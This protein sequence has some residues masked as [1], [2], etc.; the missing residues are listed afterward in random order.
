M[1]GMARTVSVSGFGDWKQLQAEMERSGIVMESASDKI[2][3]AA[4]DAGKAAAVQAEMAGKSADEQEAAAARASTAVV[5]A[6]ARITKAQQAAAAAAA[7]VAARTGASADAQ[8]AAA[9][10]AAAAAT[11]SASQITRA[12]QAAAAAAAKT[13]EAAGLS[14]DGQVAAADRAMAAQAELEAK[15]A[16]S[17]DRVSG[18]FKKLGTSMGS[19][20]IPFSGSVAKIGSDVDEAD[21]KMGKLGA[22]MVALGKFTAIAG[23]GAFAAAAY[24]GVKGAS[25]L[26]K[27]MEMIH[28]QAGASQAEVKKMTGAVLELS[29]LGTGPQKLSE[30]L[31]H[32]ESVGLRG[33]KAL[34]VLKF[35]AQ[36][37]QVGNA[38]LVDVQNA[39]DAAVVSG[40]S[41]AQ[42]YSQAM[43]ALNATV[44]SGDMKMQDLADA[45]GTGLLANVKQAGLSLGD[46]G[47]AL[48]VFGDNNLRGAEAATKLSS[49]V[50]I[51]AAPSKAAGEALGSIGI[52][53]TQ[54]GTDMQRGGLVPAI[55]DLKQHLHDSG[56][57]AAQ[58]ELVLTRA[59]GGRQSTGVKIL[60]E[61]LER[62][63]EKQKDLSQGSG[64]FGA[65]WQART[66][67]LSFQIDELEATVQKL[68][69][70]LGTALIPK[71][72]EVGHDTASVISWMEKHKAAA[73][74]LGAVIA[75]VLGAAVGA[76]AETKAVA[77]VNATKTM[78][79]G[80]GTLAS[81]VQAGSGKIVGAFATQDAAAQVSATQ[82][83]ADAEASS[84]AVEAEA[85]RI[86]AADAAIGEAAEGAA[87]TTDAALG[88]TG[89]G[90]VLV[91]LG[92][93]AYELETHWK[94]VMQ[95]L[96]EA[97]QA[98][99]NAVISELNN[100]IKVVEDL[101]LGLV[102]IDKI[103]E[104]SG[105][106]EASTQEKGG[107][108]VEAA[109]GGAEQKV[110]NTGGGIM[111][112]FESKGLTPAQ[113]A[114]IVGNFQ[115]E[116]S[117]NPGMNT[118]EGRGLDS[119]TGGRAHGGTAKQ[120]LEAY[121]KEL[122]GPEAGTLAQL[123]QA[124]S[125]REAA[126]VFEK[127]FERA[128]QPEM[129]NRE[130]FAEKAFKAHPHAA[131]SIP[132]ASEPGGAGLS[133]KALEE[134]GIGGETAAEKAK[135][136]AAALGVPA[137]VVA[138]LSTAKAL[139]GTKYT[140]GGGHDG[141]DPIAALKKIGVDCSGF[142]SQTLHRGGVLTNPVTTEGLATAPG[143][144]KGAG[145][146]VTLYDKANAGG[147]SHV[148]EEILGKYFESGGNPKYNP[149]GGVSLLT[150][151]QAK[152]ELSSGGFEAFHPS[153]LNKPVRGGADAST[154]AK[155][156][157]PQEA[158]ATAEAARLKKAEEELKKL[159]GSGTALY[160]K[161]ESDIQGGGVKILEKLLG[162]HSVVK[163]SPVARPTLT[164]IGSQSGKELDKLVAEL[165]GTHE[166]A[167]VQIADKLVAA[168]KSALAWLNVELVAE[169]EKATAQGLQIQ[170]A[171]EK[172]RTTLMADMASKVVEAMK[173]AAA[174]MV[175][176][177]DNATTALKDAGKTI[178][179]TFAAAAT[180]IKDQTQET[181]DAN[182]AAIQQIQDRSQTE[183]DKLAE[184]GLY[185]LNLVAQQQTVQLDEMKTA[186]D[187]QIAQAQQALDT[188]QT[189][190]DQGAAAVQALVDAVQTQQDALIG[191]AKL[192]LGT[193]E[194]QQDAAV[195]NAQVNLDNVTSSTDAAVQAAQSAVEKASSSTQAE[196]Q[197]AAAQLALAQGQQ[198]AQVAQAEAAL[199]AAK[200]ASSSAVEN[201]E[202]AL[203]AAE[204]HGGLAETE[205]ENALASAQGNA[206]VVLAQAAATLAE[207]Q[208]HAQL[209]EAEEKA[210]IEKTKAEAATQY[211][212]SG[213]VVNIEGINPTDA[214]AVA[215]EVGWVLRTAIPA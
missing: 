61:Q 118:A 88:S 194:A 14:A 86:G 67:T 28:T 91:G 155:G 108:Q 82:M 187:A 15:S 23:I 157:A 208:G 143:I 55:E 43:G 112:F 171:Q 210:L 31:Y 63:K 130:T 42:N 47:A 172:D 41:G 169:Q 166:K 144:S 6:N 183:V 148:I 93:A 18:L 173:D 54:L 74:A 105:A 120:Q 13:A 72:E 36:G 97:A 111:A 181:S 177:V 190:T 75:T 103:K 21:S 158:V 126:R 53:A 139:I 196:Q 161:Y 101:T 94:A 99:A 8:A 134:L 110:L 1:S 89:V 114:G 159:T 182:S 56:A 65:D 189:S 80:I 188:A 147:N 96:E 46:T 135:K 121:W 116:S 203:A 37:A 66:K 9:G 140:S 154:L 40:I 17:S 146:Y 215:S 199:N 127:G 20:G 165:R 29:G 5:E 113:A 137:G 191:Q 119:G 124:K 122:T 129:G 19:W 62:L 87:V 25:A 160:K 149:K 138:M 98:M 151:A 115:Q 178:T 76:Y 11:T 79:G 150:A 27:Q 69:D 83:G 16:E 95:G 212:G 132:S 207:V 59:F 104:L 153:A 179:D 30:S 81:G 202:A 136:T 57:T 92:V 10:R 2:Q 141:W 44:G 123:K 156:L 35:A 145:R 90:A 52:S 34:E 184:R 70:K 48:A 100:A 33:A 206:S 24:E 58:T 185:G 133:K 107:K 38:N 176:G 32:V 22:S 71:L 192:A 49:A 174:V 200:S 125:P 128:G 204:A 102:H 64:N 12:Q 152:G 26:Q 84:A 60:I 180:A 209:T 211:A 162:A 186:S 214:A 78:V 205:A 201:A 50:R 68:A 39:L 45:L 170:A 131:S 198:A 109:V 163:G 51:M 106:G 85:V 3:K 77:F 73:E 168:H 195:Q 213:L 167:L 175:D 117:L 142:V 193:T 164:T 7:E 197:K 4:A